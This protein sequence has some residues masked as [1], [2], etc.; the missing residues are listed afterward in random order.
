MG[1]FFPFVT[2]A[3]AAKGPGCKGEQ[4]KLVQTYD[5]NSDVPPYILVCKPSLPMGP[6]L[7]SHP[8][9]SHTCEQ[10]GSRVLS[11]VSCHTGWDH[12][13]NCELESDYT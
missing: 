4:E 10:K 2:A 7:S 12:S 1:K 8:E 3:S 11:S 6:V 9:F 5:H 13:T